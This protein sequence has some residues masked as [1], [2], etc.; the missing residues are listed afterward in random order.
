MIHYQ[1]DNRW[2]ICGE[3]P[4]SYDSTEALAVVTCPKCLE[5]L[6]PNFIRGSGLDVCERCEKTLYEHPSIHVGLLLLFRRCDGTWF[7][8]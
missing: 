8:T 1:Q 2:P 6:T 4:L 5:I 7:K 3:R